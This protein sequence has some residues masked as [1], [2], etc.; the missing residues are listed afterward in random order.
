MAENEPSLLKPKP[1]RRRDRRYEQELLVKHR[2]VAPDLAVEDRHQVAAVEDIS[3]GG[4]KMRVK[5]VYRV[6][7]IL[8]ISFPDAPPFPN[9]ILFAEVTWF[10][11]LPVVEQ[12]RVGC[13]FVTFQPPAP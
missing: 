8:E 3:P 10:F 5:K 7:T 2:A 13:K 1:D 4:V 6:G 9:K 11:R 12:Y